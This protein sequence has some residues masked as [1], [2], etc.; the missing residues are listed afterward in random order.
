M[1]YHKRLWMY[2]LLLH[3]IQNNSKYHNYIYIRMLDSEMWYSANVYMNLIGEDTYLTDERYTERTQQ[4]DL[5]SIV[6]IDFL[7]LGSNSRGQHDT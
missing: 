1:L 5:A 7:L 6:H 3:Q 4:R 2:G